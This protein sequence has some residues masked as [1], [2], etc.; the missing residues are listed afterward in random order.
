MYKRL[1]RR[2]YNATNCPKLLTWGVVAACGLLFGWS[3]RLATTAEL[4]N[5]FT[6][7]SLEELM[8]IEVTS[9]G[10]KP[11]R[12]VDT[13]AAVF[14]ITQE[15]LRRSGATSLPEALRMAPGLQVARIDANKWAV[16]S[17][18]FNGRFAN[19]LLV[20]MDGRTVY[21]PLFSGVY[22]EVQDTL[23]EDIERIEIIRGPGATLWGANAVNGIINI[24]TKHA[25]E[26]QG[27]LATV[28]GGSEER[29]FGSLRYGVTLH[30]DAFLRV[31][32]KFLNRDHMIDVEGQD[33]H[34]E[35]W[36]TRGG[37]RLDW[38]TSDR[39]SLTFQGDL[40]AG[41]ANQDLSLPSLAP[42][43]Q[44]RVEGDIDLFGANL[45]TRW[46]HQSSD[47][48]HIALQ[49]YYD[50]TD[51]K[52]T[53]LLKETR[54]TV[55]IDFQHQFRLMGRHEIVWGLGYRFT[56]DDFGNS[57]FTRL[58]PNHAADHLWSAFIQ[59]EIAL[60]KEHLF[61]T[62]GSKFEHNDYSGFEHQPN[63]RLRWTP[64]PTHTLWAAVSRAV[65]TPSRENDGRV[66]RFII[67]PGAPQQNPGP[68]P[69]ITA[70]VGSAD[71]DSERLVA[72]EIGYRIRPIDLL[73]FDLAAF[74]N[75]YDNL[76]SVE[77]GAPFLETVPTPPHLVLPFQLDNKAE[78]ESYGV[79]LAVDWQPF[80]WWRLHTAYTY[81]QLR[82][83]PDN[84]S[85]SSNTDL[86]EGLAPHHQ[87]SFRSQMNL[88]KGLAWDLWL[89]YVDALPSINVSDYVTLDTRLAW[90]PISGLEVSLVGRNLIAKHHLEFVNELFPVATEIKRS[91]YI[92]LAWRF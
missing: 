51:R 81:L 9:V 70:V 72:Y 57:F 54:D 33:T 88:P 48:S 15:D 5:D 53:P 89:R 13:A 18:G 10:K 74:Y 24:I 92:Q 7:L 52:E 79:E 83:D 30:P 39:D 31:Y 91:A 90:T 86:E 2:R 71:F 43:F 56:Q 42:P 38:Q 75:V 35:H 87:V 78:G 12:L 45:L 25:R 8:N 58:D 67:P 19:K 49:L 61:L 34:D 23:L 46:R 77:P 55:D 62:L 36:M 84:D 27:G 11:Q 22:W 76:R 60:I 4:H 3:P 6:D 59:D 32:F 21:T 66:N 65:R 63:I 82:I 40:Y 20:L 41:E 16:S 14:V 80:K 28:G 50:R 37:F 85:Q 29:G 73:S 64:T 1:L 44:Q 69:A 26:T 47:S 17:R 68:I